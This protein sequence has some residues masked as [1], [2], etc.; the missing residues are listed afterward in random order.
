[1]QSLARTI[2]LGYLALALLLTGLKALLPLGPLGYAPFAVPLGPGSEPIELVVWYGT[3]K[4]AWLS[5]AARRFE[6]GG[7]SAGGR[8]VR[9]RLVGMGSGEIA[10][11]V[12]RRDW[13]D[14]PPPAAV[15]PASSLWL[16]LLRERWAAG[17]GGAILAPDSPPL[18]LTPLVAVA[19]EDRG[20]LIWPDGGANFWTDL[21]DAVTDPAGW[22]GVVERR[23]YAPDSPEAQSAQRWSF[24]KLG[25]TSPLSS[26][27][28]VQTLIM[29]AYAYHGKAAGLSDADLLDPGFQAWL[30]QFERSVLDFGSSTGTF[31]ENMVLVGP[32]KYDAV[33]VYENLAI[34][35]IETAQS[36][37]G[38]SMRV[39]YPPATMFSDHPYGVLQEPLTSA[40][41]R[42]AAEAFGSFLR[43]Q[44]MQELALRYGFRPASPSV[45]VASGDP[46]NPFNRLA[47]LGVQADIA[48]QV[49]APPPSLVSGLIELW[50]V[51]IQP[52][53]LQSGG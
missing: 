20:R 39:Y 12:A 16:D 41:Q 30:E 35:Q 42:A 4:E 23:G 18:V 3:E 24:V 25:H 1:M 50:R 15:S 46:A 34:E 17:N 27:S 8:P 9:V 11:R 37:W 6:E 48:Q 2:G 21:A 38:L 31:M 33:L 13:G 7:G 52:F 26:N 32:S 49:E 22:P 19:W 51:R 47:P 5:E 53:T 29:L 10:D 43:S 28:G 45:S 40:E 44:P 14:D 36:R